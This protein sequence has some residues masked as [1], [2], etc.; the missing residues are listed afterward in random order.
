MDEYNEDSVDITTDSDNSS[1]FSDDPIELGEDFFEDIAEDTGMDLESSDEMGDL[2]SEDDGTPFFDDSAE[3]G[4]SD[5]VVDEDFSETAEG[6][7][8]SDEENDSL[9]IDSELE[10]DLEEFPLD[11][12]KVEDDSDVFS[13][14]F[15]E[16]DTDDFSLEGDADEEGA[17]SETADMIEEDVEE[18]SLD[19]DD[20]NLD[21][22]PEMEDVEEDELYEDIAEDIPDGTES[23]E[24]VEPESQD[25]E[26]KNFEELE[27]ETDDLSEETE[28]DL[29]DNEDE[30]EEFS[31]EEESD[32]VTESV[33]VTEGEEAS[34]EEDDSSV[35]SDSE[36]EY[37]SENEI[38]DETVDEPDRMAEGDLADTE[39]SSDTIESESKDI[40]DSSKDITGTEALGG[41]EISSIS[42]YMNAHNYGKEDFD[43]YSQ[44]PQWRE[45]MRQE[46][47]DYDLP[48]LDQERAK[49]QLR[50]YMFAHNYG[51][52]DYD[53]YSQDPVWRELHSTVF[54]ESE[55]PP[56]TNPSG[57]ESEMVDTDVSRNGFDAEINDQ[58]EAPGE[59]DTAPEHIEN[60]ASGEQDSSDEQSIGDLYRD[61]TEWNDFSDRLDGFFRETEMDDTSDIADDTQNDI[62][63]KPEWIPPAVEGMDVVDPAADIAPLEITRQEFD[64][65]E[66]DDGTM[67]RVFDHP[68]ELQETLPYSQGNNDYYK[69]G[70]CALAGTGARLQTAGSAY[71]ENEVVGYASTH[72][73]EYGR[74][75]CD[76]AGGTFPEDIPTIW[77]HFGMPAY[78]DY[79]KN[80]ES[81]AEAVEHGQAVQVG[82]N[83]GKLWERDN[84]EG[85][86]LNNPEND[87]Y[88]DGGANHA[89]NI[90]SCERNAVTGNITHFYIN[91]TGRSIP[92]DACRRISAEDFWHAFHVNRAVATISNKPI[93]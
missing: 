9:D 53:E 11:E 66:L 36:M 15:I 49:D 22:D 16:E 48:P 3:E 85:F 42:D 40:D 86:V 32:D 24:Y 63:S 88:G 38:P 25:A 39:M 81:I 2:S 54:P 56:L 30:I 19:D 21:I 35:I 67:A 58:K 73:N 78:N 26:E 92:R 69:D 72:E 18:F 90:M 8:M 77:G 33:D 93:W 79:S 12:E 47:P 28:L 89:I 75:L 52:E 74:P 37:P 59:T 91:D 70:T 50:D 51:A 34:S 71:G 31:L 62:I 5:D 87:C 27:E 17:D 23:E 7:E 61:D 64:V 65:R 60:A 55:L 57:N 46:Y 1:D 83:A 82:V 45:L 76:D 20:P 43:E 84:A 6:L 10:E 4:L 68:E 44:D 41:N 80:L 29:E 14:D 13:D